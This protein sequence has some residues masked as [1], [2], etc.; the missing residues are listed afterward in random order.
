M[1]M[2]NGRSQRTMMLIDVVAECQSR[3][4]RLTA[5][6]P[7]LFVSSNAS[8]YAKGFEKHSHDSHEADVTV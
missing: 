8:W 7:F 5:L 1:E 2:R 4:S 6:R 3:P